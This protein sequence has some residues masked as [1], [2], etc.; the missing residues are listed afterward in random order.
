[1]NEN[2]SIIFFK[3]VQLFEDITLSV[4]AKWGHALFLQS[5]EMLT[6]G[7]RYWHAFK[8]KHAMTKTVMARRRKSIHQV[9]NIFK[10]KYL[11]VLD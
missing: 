3:I 11:Y 4:T 1:M 7:L 9:G 2:A 5:G 6:T 8:N 10:E